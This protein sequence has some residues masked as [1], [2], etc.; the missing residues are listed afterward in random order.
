MNVEQSFKNVIGRE[1][2]HD[3][4]TRYLKFQKEFEIPDTDPT[5]IMFV[6]FE[7][8][9]RIFEKFPENARAETEKVIT[10]LREASVAVTAA[11]A[12]EVKAAREKAALEITKAQEA[13]KVA[14]AQALEKSMSAA[15]ERAI[16]QIAQSTYVQALKIQ[17]RKW[18]LIGAV[19]AAVLVMLLAGGIGWEAWIKGEEAGQSFRAVSLAE[20]HQD[21]KQ[22]F[23]CSIPGWQIR[24]KEGKKYCYPIPLKNGGV[25]GWRIQ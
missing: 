25:Y 16:D 9:Q 18:G 3:E 19:A 13:A 20:I 22:Y 8:Y 14:M 7:F 12:A 23:A 17:A 1:M 2:T 5:W 4:L 10:Q 6:Y 15:V 21:L 11:T 24:T